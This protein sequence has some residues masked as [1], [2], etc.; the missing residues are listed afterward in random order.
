MNNINEE[1]LEK[2]DYIIKEIKES[3]EFEKIV[4]EKLDYLIKESKESKENTNNINNEIDLD[5]ADDQASYTLRSFRVNT[6]LLD[7]FLSLA[8]KKDFKIQWATHEAFKL[9]IKKYA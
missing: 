5:F 9:F 2:L 8:R 3:K 1:I 6:W 7:E 4:I